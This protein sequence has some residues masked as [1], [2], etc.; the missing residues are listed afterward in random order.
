MELTPKSYRAEL[1]W[2][3]V[4]EKF[5]TFAKDS[6]DE[7]TFKKY[8]LPLKGFDIEITGPLYRYFY[9]QVTGKNEEPVSDVNEI[10]RKNSFD[11]QLQS[12]LKG[13]MNTSTLDMYSKFVGY[14]SFDDF[15]EQNPINIENLSQKNNKSKNYLWALLIIPLIVLGLYFIFKAN[16]RNETER[17]LPFEEEK[18]VYEFVENAIAAEFKTYQKCPAI[19]TSLLS[20]FYDKHCDDYWAPIFRVLTMHN[21]KKLT[22]ANAGNKSGYK[23]DKKEIIASSIDTITVRTVESWDLLWYKPEIM[24]YDSAQ[25]RKNVFFNTYKIVRNRERFKVVSVKMDSLHRKYDWKKY[26]Q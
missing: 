5:D 11:R 6:F 19:D 13:S 25:I 12:P 15:A 20:K 22:I 18:K 26:I 2:K 9:K 14:K 7:A 10:M 8:H 17:L 1:L 21:K 24:Q 23:L 16:N 4:T 3:K